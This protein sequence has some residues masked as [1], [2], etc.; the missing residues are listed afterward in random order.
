MT[1]ETPQSTTGIGAPKGLFDENPKPV[2]TT[3]T[4][5]LATVVLDAVPTD[6]SPSL[7]LATI[8]LEPLTLNSTNRNSLLVRSE[9]P[10]SDIQAAAQTKTGINIADPNSVFYAK[11]IMD[12]RSQLISELLKGVKAEDAGFAGELVISLKTGINMLEIG[13]VK[14]QLAQIGIEDGQPFFKRFV[15]SLPLIGNAYKKCELF[16]E[17]KSEV[18]GMFDKIEAKANDHIVKVAEANAK[19]G[20][21]RKDA[22]TFIRQLA[23]HI[24][25][26]EDALL[27]AEILYNQEKAALATTN[28]PEKA[29]RLREFYVRATNF[30]VRISKLKQAYVDCCSLL[31]LQLLQAEETGM[32]TISDVMDTIMFTI[33][34]FKTAVFSVAD[35]IVKKRARVASAQVREAQRESAELAADMV[36]EGYIESKKT[37]G[38]V[39]DEVVQMETIANKL[40]QALETGQKLDV[41]NAE[42]R[43]EAERKLIELSDKIAAAEKNADLHIA[44][45]AK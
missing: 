44:N 12:R 45:P 13:K 27:E 19:I 25:A 2:Q 14:E 21:L 31:E 40:L 17:K 41:E 38:D 18:A 37:Q 26:G 35:A 20:I 22:R 32:I 11:P 30:D 3:P 10:A 4:L 1:Q 5:P 23:V 42:K 6:A 8:K 7:G 28:N 9:F 33:P 39:L 36:T 34:N 43:R 24:M 29:A 16:I 15:R